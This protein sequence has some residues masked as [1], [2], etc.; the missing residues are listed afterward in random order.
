MASISEQGHAFPAVWQQFLQLDQVSASDRLHWPDWHRGRPQ[1][2]FWG[3]AVEDAQLGREMQRLRQRLS[4]FLRPDYQRSEHI[5]LYAAGFVMP[6]ASQPDETDGRQLARQAAL[7]RSAM[8]G[9][10]QLQTGAVSS[11]AGAPFVEVI[12][13]DGRLAALRRALLGCFADDR[14]VPFT[15][16]LTLGL[17]RQPFAVRLL[18]ERLAQLSLPALTIPVS[19]ISLF[20]YH[21]G[22]LCSPLKI[23]Q[24]LPC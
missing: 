1:F 18:A 4:P 24:Q 11:F 12:D 16:H 15:P 21:T 7:I 5:T 13:S 2:C 17:Y 22:H 19:A 6:Q 14:D 20:S 10:W 8:N 3:I 9:P 23:E